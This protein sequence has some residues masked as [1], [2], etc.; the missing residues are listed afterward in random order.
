MNRLLSFLIF[1]IAII[2]ISPA[3]TIIY[4]F[5][6]NPDWDDFREVVAVWSS[7]LQ[8]PGDSAGAR[9]W[10]KKAVAKYGYQNY[11][12]I[13]HEYTP[14]FHRLIKVY[15]A[16][17]L[18]ITEQDG[19]YKITTQF[20]HPKNDTLMTLCILDVYARRDSGRFQLYNART[21]NQQRD[22]S[23]QAV[24][25]LKYHFPKSHHFDKE[26]A[27]RQNAFIADTLPNIFGTRPDTVEY[28]LAD[29]REQMD[30][31]K[32]FVFNVGG[33]GTEKPSG[34]AAPNNT[35]YAIGSGEFYPHELVHIFVGP[36]FP[37]AYLWASEGLA[38]Y[39][40]GS[41]GK[42]LSWHVQ[43][44]SAYLDQH[45]EINLNN[46][47]NLVTLDQYTG[48]RYVLGGA[49]IQLIRQREGWE[50]VM[51]FLREA[52]D[53]DSYYKALEKHL[54]WKQKEIN[55]KLRSQ[56]AKMILLK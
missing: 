36:L 17:I 49:V 5:D 11:N 50:G 22:W 47:L 55:A 10:N 9:Y 14:S 28:F 37:E 32:G 38:T 20:Y 45:P 2:S 24:G 27:M 6:V 15:H 40:G 21:I 8:A 46:M 1:Q 26:M 30:A 4:N 29:T 54:G 35:V 12:L 42:S 19:L 51:E 18:K 25:Y 33:S 44:T 41:R 3:Q 16:Q 48:Y 34:K 13:N 43:R 7:Y 53:K 56:L 23:M 52:K 31:L 39:L